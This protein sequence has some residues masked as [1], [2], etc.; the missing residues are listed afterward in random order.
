LAPPSIWAQTEGDAS[1]GKTFAE[2]A[3]S[4]CHAVGKKQLRSPYGYAPSFR[5]VE[6]TP[7]MTAATLHVSFETPH[8]SM[9]NLILRSTDKENVCA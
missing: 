5:S 2:A 7:S 9:P 3:C 1:Q 4:Q 6:N 8:S